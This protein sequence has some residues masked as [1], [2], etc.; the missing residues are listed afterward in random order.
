MSSTQ[1][2]LARIHSG[3]TRAQQ[4]MCNV[5]RECLRETIWWERPRDALIA[6]LQ[7][8]AAMVLP[9][10]SHKTCV[11]GVRSFITNIRLYK[12][13]SCIF[14]SRE[15]PEYESLIFFNS[16]SPCLPSDWHIIQKTPSH[17]NMLQSKFIPMTS[18]TK[19]AI[20]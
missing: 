12:L 9:L 11:S 2:A 1:Y 4:P 14:R 6:I 10:Q 15:D 17:N 3:A 5:K 19:S 16:F 7:R 13:F 18:K 8:T 20:S